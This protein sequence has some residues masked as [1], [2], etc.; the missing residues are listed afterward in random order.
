MLPQLRYLVE[1]MRVRLASD[2]ES[3]F[4]VFSQH[5][6]ALQQTSLALNEHSLPN[7][8]IVGTVCDA[9]GVVCTH[10][11][12]R[13]GRGWVSMWTIGC[14]KNRGQCEGGLLTLVV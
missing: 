12:C 8:Q 5:S 3:K 4:V 1:D 9:L 10:A 13:F 11:F 2:P 6:E 7:V 14:G